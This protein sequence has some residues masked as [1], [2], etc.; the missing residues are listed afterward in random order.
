M[1]VILNPGH[2]TTAPGRTGPTGITEREVVEAMARHLATA[3]GQR[4][5]ATEIMQQPP[6]D[7]QE[8]LR[9]LA[10]R[11]ADEPYDVD[12]TLSL[13]CAWA[14]DP[15][16]YGTRC[17]YAAGSN[18]SR[19]LADALLRH[20]PRTAW[21]AVDSCDDPVLDHAQCPAVIIELDHLSNPE[22]EGLMRVESWQRKVAE[23]IVEGIIAFIG[24]QDIRI[25][26][27]GAEIYTDPAP[28][29]VY[30]D[31]MVPVRVLGTALGA[32]VRWDPSR[33]VIRIAT[34]GR[35]HDS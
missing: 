13:H 15:A 24:P 32:E 35:R 27:D 2:S 10:A 22:V 4:M 26:V 11:I 16:A 5:I 12:I 1:K 3:C 25:L 8:A 18:E 9:W 21:S 23:N 7:P 17:L 6:G 19:L 31:V 28:Q 30:N 33:R 34:G 20:F 29:E 14:E